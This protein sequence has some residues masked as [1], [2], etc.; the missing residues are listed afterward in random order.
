M[1]TFSFVIPT[2]N[3]Y[4]LLHQILFDIYQ[5][6]SAVD[7]VIVVD[8]ESTDQDYHDGL[9]WW[10]TNGMLPVRHVRMKENVGFLKASNAGLKRA[11]GDVVCLISND[12]RIK[13]DII[14]GI[15]DAL[16]GWSGGALVGGRFIDWD[17][18]WN[19]FENKVFGYLEGWLLATTHDAWEELFYFDEQFAP[20]DYEDI[21]LSTKAY[22]LGYDL[23]SLP[24]DMTYH[25]GGQSIGFNP[26][27]EQITLANKEK[28]RQKWMK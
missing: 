5:K 25:I 9:E 28:F 23:V 8:D 3:H 21:D 10:K 12:V 17:T 20:C 14:K 13:G 27:R 15:F 19:Q 22:A 26:E 4:P 16:S 7:E 1:K 18:G 11:N 2:F 24:P 6:C